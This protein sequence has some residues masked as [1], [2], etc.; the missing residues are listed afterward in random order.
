MLSHFKKTNAN[1][2]L[3]YYQNQDSFDQTIDEIFMEEPYQFIADNKQPFIIDA[4]S[5]IGIATLYFKRKYPDANIICFEPD[6]VAFKLLQKNI[7][8]NQLDKVELINAAVSDQEQE[9]DFFGQIY[10][11]DADARGNS[12][13]KTWGMQRKINNIIKVQAVKLSSYIQKEVDF[14]KIDI[15]GSE[16]KVL[17]DL[18]KSDKLKYVKKISLEVHMADSMGMV[19]HVDSISELLTRNQ[20]SFNIHEKILDTI[21]PKQVQSWA[22]EVRPRLLTVYA[23]K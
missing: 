8:S 23:I 11:K 19:N 18:E 6:P 7:T 9:V 5:N 4:G 1:G 15:E 22:K 21:L 12:L 14:L 13:I 17:E 10:T 3:I 16:Q 20:F 2:Y